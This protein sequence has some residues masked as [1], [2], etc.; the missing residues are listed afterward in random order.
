[1]KSITIHGIEDF[2]DKKIQEK[3]KLL[4][5]SQ[6]K[7]IK[8]LL[9]D[10]LIDKSEKRKSEYF[11]LFGCWSD[12]EKVEFDNSIKIFDEVNELDWK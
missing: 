5:L 7:T 2:L 1:M 9:E 10:S 11:D 6:N 3:S 4:G 12:A 8:T